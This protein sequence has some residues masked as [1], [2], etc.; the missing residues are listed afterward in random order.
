M[1]RMLCFLTVLAAVPF[2]LSCEPGAGN[3]GNRPA[4]AAN[5]AANNSAA[6]APVN[7]AAAEAEIKKM[8]TDVS[9]AMTKND[10]EAADKMYADNYMFI[11]PDGA[12]STK[13]ERMAAMKSG[14]TK[15]ETL[16]FE[17]TSVRVNPEGN[18]A[19]SISKVT[20]KGKN[21]GKP[22]DGVHRVSYTWTK[23]KD[24]W[25]IANTQV[26]VIAGGAAAKPD[27]SKATDANKTTDGAKPPPPAV[28][29]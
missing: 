2:L 11:G 8:L 1:R 15:I 5:N 16:T 9:T 26:T 12:I 10:S 24:G 7:M 23:T 3:A 22:A 20:V 13:A 28:N 19:V 18:G 4:N 21:M 17:D 29:K 6:P 25:K 27:D 14:D